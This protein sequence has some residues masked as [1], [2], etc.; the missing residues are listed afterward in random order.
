MS[1]ENILLASATAMLRRMKPPRS[2]PHL[3]QPRRK[4]H[5]GSGRR[6]AGWL[7]FGAVR[8]AA[9]DCH[10]V[11]AAKE[12]L[13]GGRA[14]YTTGE[15]IFPECQALPRVPKIGHSGSQSSPSVALGEELHSGKVA[16]PECLKEHD[17]RGRPSSPSATLGEDGHTKKK[18]CI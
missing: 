9:I 18:S 4:R 12:E 8:G 10:H 3:T 16:F 17:T 6:R 11:V 2:D 1:L 14:P 7:G 13:Q 15:A 5:R